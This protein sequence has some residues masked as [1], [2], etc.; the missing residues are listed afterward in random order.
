[1][2]ALKGKLWASGAPVAWI[3]ETGRRS[4]TINERSL[5]CRWPGAADPRPLAA[6]SKASHFD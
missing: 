5:V 2:P 3:A 1:L 4:T 6:L